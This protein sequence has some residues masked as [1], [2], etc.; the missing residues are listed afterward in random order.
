[1]N[2]APDKHEAFAESVLKLIVRGGIQAVSVRTVASDAGWSVGALQKTFP[3][4]EALLRA[5]LQLLV[6]R[7]DTRMETI[8]FTGDAADYL[9]RLITETLPLDQ[10]RR[11]EALA[12]NAFTAEA[13]HTQWIADMLTSQDERI[14]EQ[15]VQALSALGVPQPAIT[16]ASILAVSDGFATRLLYNPDRAE[17][18]RAALEPIIS[19]LLVM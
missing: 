15:L 10:V 18:L 13:T 16:A 14:S 1:M 5:S 4:K 17:E 7:V 19:R 9:V 8:P 3:N 11:D 2:R 6:A 12:W